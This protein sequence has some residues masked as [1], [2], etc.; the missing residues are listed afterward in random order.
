MCSPAVSR[1]SE[2]VLRRWP[3][4]YVHAPVYA[5]GPDVVVVPT[6]VVACAQHVQG[7]VSFKRT[8]QNERRRC[9]GAATSPWAWQS[10][11]F[12]PRRQGCSMYTSCTALATS[13]ARVNPRARRPRHEQM[14]PTSA[15]GVVP[16]CLAATASGACVQINGQH[17]RIAESGGNVCAVGAERGAGRPQVLVEYSAP[18]I[19]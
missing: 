15:T 5:A 1:E 3:R 7:A 17:G 6:L 16:E 4:T 13:T 14:Y 2:P 19:A 18:G 10:S 8:S 12:R 9:A 11:P